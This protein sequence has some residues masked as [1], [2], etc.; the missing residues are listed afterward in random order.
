MG[1]SRTRS[2]PPDDELVRVALS[3]LQTLVGLSAPPTMVL[4]TRWELGIPQFMLG[5]DSVI[6]S[7]KALEGAFP[8]F[9]LAGSYLDGV[10]LG[11][12]VENGLAAG[13]R[14]VMQMKREVRNAH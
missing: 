5:H 13:Q 9:V 10:A 8:G 2:L 1:G 11:E 14:A 12:C 4:P 7:A 6:S 3:E